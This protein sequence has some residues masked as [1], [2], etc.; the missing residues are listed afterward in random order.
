MDERALVAAGALLGAAL[1]DAAL[2]EPPDRAHPVAWL[3]AIVAALRRRAPARGP[4]RQLAWGAAVALVVPAG[5]A[6]FG[7]VIERGAAA[8]PPAAAALALAVALKPA[9]AIRA[10]GAAGLTVAGALERGDLGAAR[11]HLGALC[12][13]DPRRLG[14]GEV[15]GG[16]V[17]SL[18]ENLSDSVVAPL[19]AYALFGL[20]GAYAYRAINTLDAML[21]YR[22]ELEHLGKA[23]A[24]LDDVANLA[25][26]R[27]AA[28]LLLVAG[29][30]R[31]GDLRGGVRAWRRDAGATPSPN[32]GR[33]MAAAAGLLGVTLVKPGVYA[34][35]DG[36]GAL[37][38]ATIRR[39]WALVAGAA[40]LA[41]AG[42]A[43]LAGARA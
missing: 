9:F 32:A 7:V 12:S 39:G 34:L 17:A 27:I 41:V 33:P 14:P 21:G 16:A 3:G 10:L 6:T 43:A 4:G 11:A 23:A 8:V 24:R 40:A 29:A 13:R 20:P 22:G 35:G 42:A 2:G 30:A 1:L 25:P 28:A 31:S 37:D 38:G 19:L 15:A 26:A 18:A 5:A 36:G